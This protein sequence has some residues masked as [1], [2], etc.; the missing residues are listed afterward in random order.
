MTEVPGP[1]SAQTLGAFAAAPGAVLVT[2]DGAFALGRVIADGAE[3]LTLAVDP[4]HR[5]LGKGAACL[6]EFEA[7]SQERGAVKVFLEV[8]TSN[9]PARAMYTKA[10]YREDG[11]RHGYYRVK[12]HEAVDAITMSKVLT[13]C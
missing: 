4:Y 10:G 2:L 5:R 8:A 13:E 7:F 11:V 1:W 6:S 9:T 3:I 12:G